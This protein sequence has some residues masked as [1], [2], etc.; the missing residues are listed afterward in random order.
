MAQD[1]WY[2]KSFET[3]SKQLAALSN[4]NAADLI[5]DWYGVS[6]TVHKSLVAAKKAHDKLDDHEFWNGSGPQAAQASM[7]TNLQEQITDDGL[8]SKTYNMSA[9]LANDGGTLNASA[10][11]PGRHKLPKDA[12]DSE[13]EEAT[14]QL[15]QDAQRTYS[16]PMDWSR[17]KIEDAAS[18]TPGG[19]SIQQPGGGGGGGGGNSGGGSGNSPQS[20]GGGTDGLA[21]KDTKPQLANGEGQGGQG[22]GAGSGS[23][24]GSGG[25]QGAGSGSGAGGSS[26]FGS[27][28]GTGTGGSGL[29]L[30]ATTAAGYGSSGSAGGTGLASGTAGGASALR[31]GGGLPGGATS[32]AGTNPAAVGA[33]GVRGGAMG[34]MGM[35]GGA[36]AHGKGGHDEDDDHETPAILINLDN[37]YE[38]MGD[39]PKA[40]PAVIGDWSEQEKADKQAQERE[41]QRYKKLGWDVKYE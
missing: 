19:G 13:R 27:G 10:G 39:L 21:N 20:P 31:A 40:S 24:S 8:Q 41:K 22:Q 29:P 30:G 37:T 16:T 15:A 4:N 36:G 17:P 35:M 11:V 5:T 1:N 38:F 6:E 14:Y 7:R 18:E 3:I 28:T 32:G 9:A 25:G 23:G 33:A 26:P 34:P 2:G 12:T